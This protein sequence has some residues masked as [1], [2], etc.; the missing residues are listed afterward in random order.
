MTFRKRDIVN[1][2]RALVVPFPIA[3][4]CFVLIAAVALYTPLITLSSEGGPRP[5]RSS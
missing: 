1:A 5:V 4:L 2:A 3:S